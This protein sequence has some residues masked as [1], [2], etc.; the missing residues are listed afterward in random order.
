[1]YTPNLSCTSPIDFKLKQLKAIGLTFEEL[2]SAQEILMCSEYLVYLQNLQTSLIKND[3]RFQNTLTEGITTYNT[4]NDLE[5]QST[6]FY[7]NYL[8]CMNGVSQY[9][10]IENFSQLDDEILGYSGI[11]N[12]TSYVNYNW[13]NYFIK[14]AEVEHH[15]STISSKQKS[16]TSS[17]DGLKQSQKYEKD[18]PISEKIKFLEKTIIYALFV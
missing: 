1:M 15:D 9:N 6:N 12:Q 8:N 13:S 7:A 18:L 17:A 16:V 5:L 3:Q 4:G 14:N 10:Q 11:N 2:Q